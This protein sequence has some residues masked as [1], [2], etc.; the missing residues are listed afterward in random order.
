M[1][2]LNGVRRAF[3]K[4]ANLNRRFHSL[5]F[6]K[7]QVIIEYKALLNGIEVKYLTKHEVRNTS[8]ECH[9]C[10]HVAQV[11]G[12]IYKCPSCGMEYDRDLNACINIVRR[13]MSSAR[14]GRSEPPKP[15]DVSGSV[16]LQANAGSSRLS[17]VE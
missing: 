5:P 11:R 13:I 3:K 6:R 10:G 9:R 2:N 15:A 14:C 4:S 1:E 7:L 12:R 17:V 16:K 8:K